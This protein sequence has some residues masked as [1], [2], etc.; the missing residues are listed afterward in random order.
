MPT[1]PRFFWHVTVNTHIF[2]FGPTTVFSWKQQRRSD[3]KIAHKNDSWHSCGIRR[4][5]AHN[6]DKSINW[7]KNKKKKIYVQLPIQITQNDKILIG[8]MLYTIYPIKL[9]NTLPRVHVGHH[10]GIRCQVSSD[11]D[12]IFCFEIINSRHVTIFSRKL[13]GINMI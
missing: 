13:W 4:S 1:D 12:C 11:I 6:Y 5:V 8:D 10:F 9:V 2:L 3:I 7:C